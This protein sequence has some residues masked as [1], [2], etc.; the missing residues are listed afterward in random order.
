MGFARLTSMNSTATPID[1]LVPRL[2]KIQHLIQTGKLTEAAERL[3][4][5]MKAT[6]ADA[7]VYLMGS[8]LAEA[9][10]NAKGAE[11][12][13][14][15]AVEQAPEWPVAVTELALLLARQNKLRE[16][17]D[18]AEQ[19]VR[20]D[21]NDP[22]LMAR[23]TD[24]AHRAQ[25]FELALKWLRRS[26]ELVPGDANVQLHMARDLRHLGRHDEAMAIYDKLFEMAPDN[27]MVLM[28]RAQTALAAGN[29]DLAR[30]DLETLLE[31]MPDNEEVKFYLER[32]RGNTPA[33]Q[34]ATIIRSLYDGFASLYDQHVVAG[35]K[36]KLPREVARMIVER[37]AGHAYNVLDLGCG[38]GLLGACLGR[39]PGSLVGVEL[40][41]P[42]IEQAARHNVYD[43]FHNV[44]LLDALE[45]TPES[46]YDVIAALD[47]FIYAGDM[48]AAI[49]NAFRILRSGGHFMFS[50]EEATE[51]EANLVLR[52]TQRYAHKAS[53]VEALCRAAG[54][55]TVTLERL[56]LRYEGN[57][58]IQGFLLTAKK[59]G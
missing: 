9:A 24:I 59:A 33:R 49:P 21:G 14:R 36:Y 51:D 40:S 17:I 6:P 37:Y 53:H 28:G 43:K 57:A 32:A 50:C 12:G 55:E 42:M 38:T 56:P 8:R 30:K 34:P 44:D 45:A 27:A 13:A 4:A 11:E 41:P 52:P 18:Y 23:V 46:L 48:T 15:K 31:Q 16:A 47:V 5:A 39:I 10:G 54:F 19:A 7:R 26:A 2:Q 1:P 3:N 58:P 29:R 25:H 22:Q 20:L 35:L